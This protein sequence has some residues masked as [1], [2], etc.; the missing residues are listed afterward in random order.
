MAT[1]KATRLRETHR[2]IPEMLVSDGLGGCDLD[3]FDDDL[4]MSGLAND[5]PFR[6]SGSGA[7]QFNYSVG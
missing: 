6:V 1:K 4:V 7:V 5:V 2:P 3:E